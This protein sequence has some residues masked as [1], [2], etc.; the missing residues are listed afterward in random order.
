[1]EPA[2]GADGAVPSPDLVQVS[3]WDLSIRE[4][5]IVVLLALFPALVLPVELL[6][7]LKLFACLGFR[8]IARKNILGNATRQAVFLCIAESPGIGLAAIA[9]R[10][11]VSRGALSYHLALLEF[12]HVV[13][14]RKI[15]GSTGYF[16]NSGRYGSL[17]QGLLGCLRHETARKI[18]YALSDRPARTR[19]DLETYLSL[20][21]PTVT[22]H[23]KR[24]EEDGLLTRARDGRFSRYSLTDAAAGYVREHRA[25]GFRE[26]QACLPAPATLQ[27]GDLSSPD[28]CPSGL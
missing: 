21:G 10:T 18:L 26:C 24:L 3:F 28:P 15:H 19:S 6:F 27:G 9:R 11:Q 4:M 14:S 5:A 13:V 22:W 20:S 17:E 12:W 7:A 25:Q 2:A 16:E 8:R 1:V 23:I